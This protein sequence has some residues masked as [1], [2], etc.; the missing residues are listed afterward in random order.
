MDLSSIIGWVF[1]FA[2]IIFGITLDKIG[3]FVDESSLL[4]V[5]GGTIF[6]VVAS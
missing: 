6:A 5:L 1:G 3:N 4:I 2:I